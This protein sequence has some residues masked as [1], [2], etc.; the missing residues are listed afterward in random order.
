MFLLPQ[1]CRKAAPVLGQEVVLASVILKDTRSSVAIALPVKVPS[2][3]E[4]QSSGGLALPQAHV[5]TLGSPLRKGD[6]GV[7]FSSQGGS[8]L[9]STLPHT[10]KL[11]T[12]KSIS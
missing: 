12:L 4:S 6:V 2:V 5:M 11:R 8:W 7:S 1:K 3:S 9:F 10:V